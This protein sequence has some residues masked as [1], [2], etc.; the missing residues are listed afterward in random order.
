MRLAPSRLQLIGVPLSLLTHSVAPPEC[1]P[2]FFSRF[3]LPG[4]IWVV[5]VMFGRKRD[6]PE[7]FRTVSRVICE[8]CDGPCTL[9]L[10]RASRTGSGGC[11]CFARR[12][13]CHLIHLRA[14]SHLCASPAAHQVVSTHTASLPP[15]VAVADNHDHTAQ[16]LV[17]VDC[18]T[19]SRILQFTPPADSWQV[20]KPRLGLGRGAVGNTPSSIVYSCILFFLHWC[21]TVRQVLP[22]DTH[23]YCK[24]THWYH[25]SSS[26][27]L[28]LLL[29]CSG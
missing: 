2:L 28:L 5:F 26:S 23:T 16:P 4:P 6:A 15:R 22:Y 9:L 1:A 20:S 8:S 11:P 18:P 3:F 24:H 10:L 25:S 7:W 21:L 14:L 19:C 12:T 17:L 13:R 27:S 29:A